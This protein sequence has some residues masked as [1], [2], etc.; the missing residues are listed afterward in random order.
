[1]WKN[2]SRSDLIRL[3]VAGFCAGNIM[4]LAFATYFGEMGSLESIFQ[5][6]QWVLYVPVVSFVAWPFYQGFMNGIRNRSLSI[7]GPM[8]I[9]SFL[10][11]AVSTW[12]LLRGHGSI[13]FDSL[14]GFLFLILST[15]Y[16]QK[17]AR[18]EYL[19]YLRPSALAETTKARLLNEVGWTWAPSERL[20]VD[21][22]ILVERNEWVPADGLLENPEAVIDLSILNGESYPRRI[23]KGFMVKAGARLLTSEMVLKVQKSGNQTFLAHLL[24]SLKRETLSETSGARL[25]DK[26]SQILLAVVLTAAAVLIVTGFP[27]QFETHFE[28]ALALIIL[29]CPC[30]MAFGTPLAYAFAMKR[31]QENG[32]VL[33]SARTF[34]RLAEIQQVF[35]DKTGTLTETHWQ[36][37]N[38]SLSDQNVDFFKSLILTLEAKSSH[39]IAFALREIWESTP[40]FSNEF[41]HEISEISSRGVQGKVEGHFWK[42]E[43]FLDEAKEKWFGL[44][45]DGELVW[46]FQLKSTLQAGAKESLK[47]IQDRGYQIRLISGDSMSDCQT[48]ARQLDLNASD[49]RAELSPE[50]KLRLI[51]ESPL[52][53]M[54]GDGINDAMALKKAHV[55]IAVR[56]SVDMALR[57]ADVL[58]LN[59]GLSSLATLFDL[60]AKARR[61]IRRNLIS[62]LLYNSFGAALAFSG[63]VNPFVAALLMPASSMFIWTSTWYGMRK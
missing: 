16:W 47:F 33:K 52:S 22:R 19:R 57:A 42:F 60:S 26:A 37:Q 13:Y 48:I 34:E 4:L 1:M 46:Q 45:R 63:L 30:A 8:A 41:N 51:E 54:V 17:R 55:G 38:S 44:W 29:A 5:W 2:E 21:D 20:Q 3:A 40:T 43:S 59:Q 7:D 62:A 6:F 56:G 36:V 18:F 23:Q 9:A 14:S 28:K 49:V 10:G 32:I 58:F 24:A 50:E 11:F 27:N 25:S 53:L 35:L 15:R 12:N 61:Q 31:A 39:P